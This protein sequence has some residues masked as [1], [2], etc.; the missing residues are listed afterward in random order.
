MILDSSSPR[1]LCALIN[2]ILLSFVRQGYIMRLEE[3]NNLEYRMATREKDI[4]ISLL[5][6][7]VTILF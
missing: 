1:S 5:E 3:D 6:Y 7:F 2:I 4:Y